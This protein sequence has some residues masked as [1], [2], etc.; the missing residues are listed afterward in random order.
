MHHRLNQEI[1]Y[2]FRNRIILFNS[3]HTLCSLTH[4]VW[5]AGCVRDLIQR[6]LLHSGKLL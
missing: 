1:D 6:L 5:L 4:L 2:V 3:V